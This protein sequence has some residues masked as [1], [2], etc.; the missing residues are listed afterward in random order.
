VDDWDCLRGMMRA[1]DRQRRASACPAVGGGG[2]G[3]ALG[4]YALRHARLLAALCN[5][6]VDPRDLERAVAGAPCAVGSDAEE[7]RVLG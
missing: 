6:R 4:Q 7:V 5:A 2:G 3:P 1:W